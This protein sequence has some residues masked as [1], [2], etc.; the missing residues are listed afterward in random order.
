M[1]SVRFLVFGEAKP[2]GSKR[3]YVVRRRDGSAGVALV[4]S[5]KGLKPWRAQVAAAA[6]A[7]CRSGRRWDLLGGP[8][9]LEVRV[10]RKRPATH[11]RHG[12]HS[13]MLSRKATAY[14]TGKPDGDKLLRAICDALTGVVWRDDAQ[15]V[16]AFVSK[17]WDDLGAERVEITV[18]SID[19]GAVV[20]R[21]AA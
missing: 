18:R 16:D 19:V 17:R 14:P 1:A 4:E 3:G 21:G 5:S 10:F 15:V 8:V 12:K 7:A 11:Y 13:Q 2:Q 6:F 9:S 20:E